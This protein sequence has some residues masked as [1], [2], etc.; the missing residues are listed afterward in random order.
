MLL[1]H[2]GCTIE[3]FV[4]SGRDADVRAH[5]LRDKQN[6]RRRVASVTEAAEQ[7][8]ALGI[9]PPKRLGIIPEL[10][11]YVEC[12]ICG[13]DALL[14]GDDI[15]QSELVV[16]GDQDDMWGYELVRVGADCFQC[17]NCGLMLEGWAHI[18]A[19]GL[20]RPLKLSVTTSLVAP[21]TTA[22]SNRP[23]AK[24]V[25]PSSADTSTVSSRRHLWQR[26]TRR[27]CH[28]VWWLFAF[29]VGVRV[30]RSAQLGLPA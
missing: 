16:D 26:V 25:R 28:R 5:L 19:A 23:T 20:Q 6:V 9:A 13:D 27:L 29:Q 2:R 15:E 14:G 24:R 21:T 22:T 30:S 18:S 17:E 1:D 7:R 8:L 11:A 10:D 3:D 4:G 12:P